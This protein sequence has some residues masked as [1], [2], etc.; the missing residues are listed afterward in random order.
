MPNKGY[1]HYIALPNIPRNDSEMRIIGIMED[2]RSCFLLP[3][4]V[5]AE[6]LDK[7]PTTLS[8]SDV[9]HLP[10]SSKTDHIELEEKV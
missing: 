6:S 9:V 2:C 8:A 1:Q 5:H 10:H 4:L 3:P 7:V